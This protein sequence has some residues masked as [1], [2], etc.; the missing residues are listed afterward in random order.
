MRY[1]AAF[2]VWPPVERIIQ[3]TENRLPTGVPKPVSSG[4]VARAVSGRGGHKKPE[5]T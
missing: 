5:E 2:R 3:G 1:L 4:G